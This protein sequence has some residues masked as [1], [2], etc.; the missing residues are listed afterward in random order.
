ME[1]LGKEPDP[2]KMPLRDEDFP[3]E[4]QMAFYIHSMLPDVWDGAG[5]N[6]FGKNWSA[7]GTILDVYKVE[8]SKDV[9]LFLKYIDSFT[10]L[11]KNDQIDKKRKQQER[12]EKGGI[13]NIPP[14]PK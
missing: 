12:K 8:N 13:G 6:Y 1:A 5:G 11:S 14:S 10:T 9:I 3:Y 4:V 7:L 2:H